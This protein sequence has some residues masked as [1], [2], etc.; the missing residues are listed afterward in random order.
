[1]ISVIPYSKKAVLIQ[2]DG[3]IRKNTLSEVNLLNQKIQGSGMEIF[4]ETIPAF[5]SITVCYNNSNFAEVKLEIEKLYR[6]LDLTNEVVEKRKW[7]LPLYINETL[8]ESILH[9]LNTTSQDFYEE[10]LSLTFTIGMK[11]FL[12]GFIYLAG[13][14]EH[15]HIPRKSTPDRSVS[16][17]SVAIGGSQCGIYPKNS[18]GG[19]H[20]IGNCPI[21]LVDY[22]DENLSCFHVGDEIQFQ[23]IDE[24][25]FKA[26]SN[27]E[28]SMKMITKEFCYE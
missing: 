20:I 11:G 13:L 10:L 23:S 24:H 27:N 26:Y 21:P 8:E 9:L 6:Q 15:L 1:M 14:P 22:N 18:P 7:K 5:T 19:W 3:P 17:G 28:W 2:W 16:K 12:P 25:E 4:T